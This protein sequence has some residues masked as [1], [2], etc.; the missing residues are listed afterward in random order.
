MF[1]KLFFWFR[2]TVDS[3]SYVDSSM[4]KYNN[5]TRTLQFIQSFEF[6]VILRSYDSIILKTIFDLLKY[7]FILYDT[8][9]WMDEPVRTNTHINSVPTTLFHTYLFTRIELRMQNNS[10]AF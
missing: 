3:H 8:T 1:V 7:F 2:R 5:G 4:M 9:A 6:H 10:F